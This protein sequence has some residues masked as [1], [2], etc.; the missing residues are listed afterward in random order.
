MNSYHDEDDYINCSECGLVFDKS[1]NLAKH[2]GA[3]HR[4]KDDD[5]VEQSDDSMEE[6]EAED[7]DKDQDE[8]EDEDG[9]HMEQTA[10]ESF[11][12]NALKEVQSS[13]K[14]QEKFEEL[15]AEGNTDDEA[16]EMTNSELV[17]QIEKVALA[18]YRDYLT[19]ALLLRNGSVH[20]DV[21]DN[22]LDFWDKGF[23]AYKAAKMA[24]NKHRGPVW[25]LMEIDSDSS[26]SGS[27]SETDSGADD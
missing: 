13:K 25:G 17:G 18:L 16:V 10:F 15:I 22:L 7:E 6:S 23:S 12:A 8:E 20:G 24:V 27:D 3:V 19:N 4:T 5:K 9:E 2:V 21:Q 26:E 1:Q 14:W 11:Y